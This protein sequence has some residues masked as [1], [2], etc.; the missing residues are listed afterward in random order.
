MS[1]K[2]ETLE[3]DVRKADAD[4]KPFPTF[5]VWQKNAHLESTRWDRY[6]NRLNQL[7]ESANGDIAR[8]REAIEVA[9]A[10]DTGALEG[11]YETDRGFTYT[12]A[13]ESAV[14]QTVVEEAKGEKVRALIEAQLNAFEYVL[15]F[16]TKSVPITSAWIRELHKE[17]CREQDTY[18][19][20]TELGLQDLPL[21][22]GEYKILPNHVRK[23]DGSIHSHAPVDL[24]VN[25]MLRLCDEL[26]TEDFQKAH[27]VLQASYAHYAFVLIHPFAD[28][29]GRVSRALASIYTYRSQSIPLLIF[30]DSRG[31]YLTALEEA[32]KG[33]YQAFVDFIL[34][35]GLS[36]I[37]L[38][39]ESLESSIE[40]DVDESVEKIKGLYITKGGYSHKE[41][42][43]AGIRLSDSFKNE[44]SRQLQDYSFPPNISFQVSGNTNKTKLTSEIY[45][46]PLKNGRNITLVFSAKSPATASVGRQFSL[47]V[48]KDCG[49]SDD[50]ILVDE[51]VG[52]IFEARTTELFPNITATIQMRL[53]LFA[54]KI[55]RKALDELFVQANKKLKQ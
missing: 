12:V 35:V 18:K 5:S 13:F 26:N 8:V 16:A 46:H 6:T 31:N 14:W 52:E 55:I 32:D 10:I 1:E 38:F 23:Q 34:E 19:A 49:K 47:Q 15:D 44:L 29:N 25:E 33:N 45:R 22:K 42:D 28:G 17:I 11:L 21:P 20:Y 3:F 2:K 37:Q 50:F 4:Y 54:K 39:S 7:K 53:K 51:N 41:V 43:E 48:P 24:T 40:K 30:S 9:T 27:P 36:S